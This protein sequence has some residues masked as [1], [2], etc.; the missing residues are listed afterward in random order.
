M[1]KCDQ[2]WVD[3][4]DLVKQRNRKLTG[5]AN[6][7]SLGSVSQAYRAVDQHTCTRLRRWLCTKHK[8]SWGPAS[9]VS[10]EATFHRR[11]GRID[12]P[13]ARASFSRA[14]A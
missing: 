2:T 10:T 5:W 3:T 14:Q 8:V 9:S 7:F 12:L 13:T 11:L 1:T 6:Y 4:E